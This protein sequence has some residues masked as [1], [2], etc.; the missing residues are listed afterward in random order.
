MKNALSM[1]VAIVLS[2]LVSHTV[3]AADNM[4]VNST[5][6]VKGGIDIWPWGN[7]IRFPWTR[8]QGTWV[9]TESSCPTMFIFKPMQ[10]NAAGERIMSIT[11]Y[12]A[13]QCKI[14]AVGI[15]YET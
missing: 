15:G 1:M 14:L 3:L 4:C 7:E 5:S 9:S 6:R 8:I 12:D 13:L 11:Q 2:L 10:P